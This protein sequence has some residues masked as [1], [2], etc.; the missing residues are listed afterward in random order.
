MDYRG[1][2]A[3]KKDHIL[4]TNLKVF[5]FSAPAVKKEKH[6]FV[7]YIFL[8]KIVDTDKIT[9]SKYFFLACGQ[10]KKTAII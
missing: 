6:L 8:R 9:N 2:A 5:F 10:T 1:A 3:S 4:V 7:I